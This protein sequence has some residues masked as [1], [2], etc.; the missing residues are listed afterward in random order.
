MKGHITGDRMEFDA[1]GSYCDN[2]YDL[3]EDDC[4]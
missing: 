2:H 1:G 3:Q 4:G